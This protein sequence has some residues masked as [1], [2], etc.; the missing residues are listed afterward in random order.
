L[1]LPERVR[2]TVD[3]V[4]LDYVPQTG[5]QKVALKQPVRVNVDVIDIRSKR[6]R[7][8]SQKNG[9][10]ME[11]AASVAENNVADVVANAI[12]AE[13]R[14]RG[15]Q[16]GQGEAWSVVRIEFRRA[17]ALGAALSDH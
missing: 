14:S 15:F 11:M 2:V 6:D 5:V 4:T 7:V 12:V 13:L 16:I 10:G 1:A 9:Y 8:S 17:L 3:R